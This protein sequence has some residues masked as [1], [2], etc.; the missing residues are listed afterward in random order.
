[1]GFENAVRMASAVLPAAAAVGHKA[2]PKGRKEQRGQRGKELRLFPKLPNVQC[3]P[4]SDVYGTEALLGNPLPT[5]RKPMTP[6]VRNLVGA[7]LGI[8]SEPQ[9]PSEGEAPGTADCGTK[10]LSGQKEVGKLQGQSG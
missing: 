4:H 6:M 8:L 9:L 7:V 5:L 3:L 10:S 2:N 1:M